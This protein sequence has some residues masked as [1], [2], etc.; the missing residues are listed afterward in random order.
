[1]LLGDAAHPMTPNLGQGACQALE[2]A[3]VLAPLPG[4]CNRSC[5]RASRLQ[6]TTPP[7]HQPACAAI[8]PNW[9]GRAVAAPAGLR[10]ARHAFATHPRQKPGSPAGSGGRIRCLIT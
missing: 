7:A 4:R 1:M 9:A 8:A 2:D 6:I 5:R 10:A 3:V